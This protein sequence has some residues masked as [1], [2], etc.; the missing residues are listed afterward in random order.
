[1]DKINGVD[2]KMKSIKWNHNKDNNHQ[3]LQLEQ[4]I[5]FKIKL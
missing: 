3:N 4:Q 5:I 2:N 1:M